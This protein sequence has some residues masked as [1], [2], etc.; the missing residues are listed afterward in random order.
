MPRLGCRPRPRGGGPS[1]FSPVAH[2]ETT[3]PA[4][5]AGGATPSAASPTLYPVSIHQAGPTRVVYRS[6]DIENRLLDRACGCGC[7]CAWLMP[8]VSSSSSSVCVRPRSVVLA[9]VC[10]VLVKSVWLRQGNVNGHGVA[11]VR[12]VGMDEPDGGGLTNRPPAGYAACRIELRRAARTTPGCRT[13]RPRPVCARSRRGRVN[14][15]A[16]G[17][18]P[19]TKLRGARAR[20]ARTGRHIPSRGAAARTPP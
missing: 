4:V 17:T 6:V 20:R 7:R 19:R 18:R 15:T 3:A 9:F 11:A 14:S 10:V 8:S 2:A 1:S 5:A 13:R 12:L 16:P